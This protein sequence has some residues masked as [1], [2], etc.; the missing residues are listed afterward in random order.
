MMI[1]Q[2]SFL[3][4][5]ASRQTAYPVSYHAVRSFASSGKAG[6]IAGMQDYI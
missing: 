5:R 4:Q 2:V 6:R 3:F 1:R